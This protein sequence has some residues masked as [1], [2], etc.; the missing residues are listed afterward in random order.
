MTARGDGSGR[1]EPAA[2]AVWRWP[3]QS[4]KAHWCPDGITAACKRWMLGT[5]TETQTASMD[6]PGPDDCAQCWRAWR[7]SKG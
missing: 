5:I 1:T 2:G 7:K 6:K 4:R 3:M